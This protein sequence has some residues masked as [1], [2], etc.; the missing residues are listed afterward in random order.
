MPKGFVIS[1]IFLRVQWSKA[2]QDIIS[3]AMSTTAA[4]SSRVSLSLDELLSNDRAQKPEEELEKEDDEELDETVGETV[5]S[6]E[7]G[8]RESPFC[9][10]SYFGTP[11]LQP[12][13][14][15]GFPGKPCGLGPFPSWSWFFLLCLGLRTCK[16]GSNNNCSKGRYLAGNTRL[17]G[18]MLGALPS[19]PGKIQIITAI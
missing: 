6:Y 5:E 18:G 16:W 3:R 14:C 10:G 7:D 11:P 8:P 17:S 9:R 15:V 12:K 19:L 4:G 13:K 2:C 1:I